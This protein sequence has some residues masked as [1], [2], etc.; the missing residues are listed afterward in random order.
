MRSHKIYLLCLLCQGRCALPKL[1]NNPQKRK[2]RLWEA[3][4]PTQKGGDSSSR[5]EHYTASPEHNPKWD[6]TGK[7]C[8]DR[9]L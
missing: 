6:V 2:P 5:N 9:Y 7:G 4:Y 8:Q 1:G 3:G